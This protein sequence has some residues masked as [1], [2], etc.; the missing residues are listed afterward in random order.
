M[1]EAI[2]KVLFQQQQYYW[3]KE[4]SLQLSPTK[5]SKRTIGKF[6]EIT[7]QHLSLR[8]YLTG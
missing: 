6:L 1:S 5:C 2:Y 3:L 8:L 7:F 4:Y